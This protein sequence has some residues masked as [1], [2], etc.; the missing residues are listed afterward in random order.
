MWYLGNN[1]GLYLVPRRDAII[2]INDD[3]NANAGLSVK[4][5]RPV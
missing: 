3:K 2:K 4:L 1:G 5:Q